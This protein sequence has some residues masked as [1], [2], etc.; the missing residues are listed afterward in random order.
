MSCRHQR[1]R[2]SRLAPQKGK[3][4]A[5][6]RPPN[7]PPTAAE[8]SR[9]SPESHR[10]TLDPDRGCYGETP[11]GPARGRGGLSE[12]RA[13]GQC[14][15]SLPWFITRISVWHLLPLGRHVIG[16]E[17]RAVRKVLEAQ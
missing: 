17:A 4:L 1:K 15:P 5:P 13:G 6:Y 8:R 16:P 10:S 7:S 11:A 3:P 2:R 14:P 12:G 9:A